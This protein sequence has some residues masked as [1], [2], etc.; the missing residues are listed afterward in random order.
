MSGIGFENAPH[1]RAYPGSFVGRQLAFFH[2]R[3]A[4]MR[5]SDGKLDQTNFRKAVQ[6]IQTGFEIMWVSVPY[7]SNSWGA[8]QVMVSYDT[9][10]EFPQNGN[11]IQDLLRAEL[12]D[13]NV[14][15]R[16]EYLVGGSGNGLGFADQD[17]FLSYVD[18]MYVKDDNGIPQVFQGVEQDEL[19]VNYIAWNA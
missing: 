16:R 14:V 10:N 3:F 8:F 13:G 18:S 6:V 4:D 19:T 11:S 5:N 17:T 9:G 7:V 1:Y 2:V 15:F 12:S